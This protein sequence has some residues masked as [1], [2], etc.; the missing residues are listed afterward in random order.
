MAVGRL[1]I[2]GDVPGHEFHGN[3]WT[4]AHA[5][6]KAKEIADAEGWA[7]YGKVFGGQIDYPGNVDKDLNIKQTHSRLVPLKELA[8]TQDYTSVEKAG[9]IAKGGERLEVHVAK[10]GDKWAILDGHHSAIAAALRGQDSVRVTV[11]EKKVRALGGPGSGNFGHA[12][13]PG[14]VGGSGESGGTPISELSLKDKGFYLEDYQ[15]IWIEE[16][17]VDLVEL[18]IKDT[19]Q[20]EYDHQIGQTTGQG[21][22]QKDD[23]TVLKM[24]DDWKQ[25]YRLPVIEVHKTEKGYKISDGQHRMVAYS[26]DH[27]TIPALVTRDR[28]HEHRKTE[29]AKLFRAESA[30]RSNTPI[31]QAADAHLAKLSVAVRYAFVA[32]RRA[33]KRSKSPSAAAKAV[34][35]ALEDVLPSVLLNVVAAGG[36]AGLGMLRGKLCAAGDVDSDLRG[37]A[38]TKFA[39]NVKDPLAVRWALEHAAELAVGI[40]DTT[41][42]AIKAAV[43]RQLDT[44]ED[45]YDAILEAV[46][47]EARAETI[48]RTE[49]MTAASEGQRQGW[50]QAI[51]KGLL[52]EDSTAAWI[53]TPGCCD[54]CEGLDGETRT[55]DGSYPD[56][57]GDGPPLHPNCRCTEGIV[58]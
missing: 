48:A 29:V 31:H 5:S 47:S 40:S 15:K 20:H 30:S 52:P 49:V 17:L 44:G 36:D 28:S 21:G 51:D 39:F 41:E 33:F 12:G 1:R 16:G 6:E 9:R 53:S 27:D 37:L 56:P 26:V 18:P 57:G 23:R 10:V 45:S 55:L 2:A 38:S 22:I 32:G 13:R 8:A 14:E 25:G 3:Q 34:R 11:H 7:V 43:A 54:L 24:L 46:G 42:E 50:Q 4:D 19:Y 35:V 58:S